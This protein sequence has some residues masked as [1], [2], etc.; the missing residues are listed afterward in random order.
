M[1]VREQ[2]QSNMDVIITFL[3]A[4]ESYM[5]DVSNAPPMFWDFIGQVDT[6]ELEEYLLKKASGQA[7]MVEAAVLDTLNNIKA[8]QRDYNI[9][10]MTREDYFSDSNDTLSNELDYYSAIKEINAQYIIGTTSYQRTT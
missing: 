6:T 9:R 1:A 8:W 7:N 10:K 4:M 2:V 3:E 5:N